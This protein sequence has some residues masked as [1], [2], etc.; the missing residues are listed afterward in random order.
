M[1]VIFTEEPSMKAA[2]DILL[3]KIGVDDFKIYP[4]QGAGDLEKSLR[5]KLRAWPH[6]KARFLIIRD[7]DRGDCYT[8]KKKLME[9]VE[10]AGKKDR[11]R[12]RIVCQELEAWFLGDIDALRSSGI[13]K[14]KG[15]PSALRQDPDSIP[16]PVHILQK[17]RPG[18]QKIAGAALIARHMQPENNKSNSFSQTLRAAKL[19]LS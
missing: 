4:H 1:L 5:T 19:L 11:A 17:I 14:S 18:Y 3:P 15:T 9:I 2:L 8:R 10:S 16:H 13:L 12:V 7:N 6:E